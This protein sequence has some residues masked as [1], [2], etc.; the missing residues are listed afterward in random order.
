MTSPTSTR[1]LP[2][3]RP[4]V[5][6]WI[7]LGLF[8]G[9]MALWIVGLFVL[10]GWSMGG[11]VAVVAL[12]LVLHASLT[13]EVLHGH[14]FPSR[15]AS[16]ALVVVNPGLFIPYVRFRDTHLAHHQDANLT[17]P[18]DDP[19][20]NYLDPEV[21]ARLPQ[22][23]RGVLQVNNTLAGRMLVGPL[24][25]QVVFMREDWRAILTSDRQVLKAWVIHVPGV[26]LVLGLVAAAPLPLWLYLL[27]CYTALSVLK[28]RTF[29]EH[30][31]HEKARGR[32]VIVEDRG[33]LAFL[34]LNNNFHVVHH[35][36]P[37]VPWYRLPALYRANAARYL[38]CND[39][40]RYRSY[41]Q[42]FAAHFWRAKDPV[43]HPLWPSDR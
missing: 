30:Q 5:I 41:A 31:A 26:M 4:F 17:D 21:W 9:C 2:K 43:P 16:E 34:F 32:T 10:P 12:A 15:L 28:I 1:R 18:Y 42:V 35:M 23:M 24:V 14:P 40:Y 3:D 27:A 19:E 22:A 25:A 38:A 11:A 13:H 39:G 37:R 36:H 20:S 6:E 7:T 29:L 8:V 33:P